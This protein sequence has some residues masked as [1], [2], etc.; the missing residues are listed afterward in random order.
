MNFFFPDHLNF[1]SFF[2]DTFKNFVPFFKSFWCIIP[3]QSIHIYKVSS[4]SGNYN[5]VSNNQGPCPHTA[6]SL[7]ERVD[8]N[9]LIAVKGDDK[10]ETAGYC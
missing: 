10:R 4:K 6:Y 5:S 7:V 1:I 3:T 9:Q 2:L 8:K